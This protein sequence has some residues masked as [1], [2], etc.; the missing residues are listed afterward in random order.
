[1]GR[2]CGRQCHIATFPSEE[3]QQGLFNTLMLVGLSSTW[4]L[5]LS[6]CFA[7][8]Y[9]DHPTKDMSPRVE[10]TKVIFPF[11]FCFTIIFETAFTSYQDLQANTTDYTHPSCPS[12]YP[13]SVGHSIYQ[14]LFCHLYKKAWPC[15]P[16]T[17]KC[18][19]R[20]FTVIWFTDSFKCLCCCLGSIECK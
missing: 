19:V 17:S 13:I 4:D 7:G 15:G 14:V 10:E 8:E 6:A 3:Y 11:L 16:R 5:P 9:E 12:L 2:R 1:M 20:C 18:R